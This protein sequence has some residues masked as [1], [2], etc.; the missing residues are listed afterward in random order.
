MV[1][2]ENK[3]SVGGMFPRS[4]TPHDET[5]LGGRAQ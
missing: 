1:R 4:R 5:V 3:V 2:R